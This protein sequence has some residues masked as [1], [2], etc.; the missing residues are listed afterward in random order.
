MKSR[1]SFIG[2]NKTAKD[3]NLHM[4]VN[5]IRFLVLP[6]TSVKFLASKI[7][8]LN[9]KLIKE[10]WPVIYQ[11]PI[12]LLETFVERDRFKGTCYKAANWIHVGE[13]KGTSK[14]GHD[15]MYHGNIKDVYLYPLRKDFRE[16]LINGNRL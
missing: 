11:H 9:I 1:E 10:D 7:L 15:H 8:A 5:N 13:T 6:W 16:K 12:Y 2:W 14:K 3:Q 4:V